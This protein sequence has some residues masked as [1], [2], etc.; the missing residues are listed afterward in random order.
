MKKNYTIVDEEGIRHII[1]EVKQGPHLHYVGILCGRLMPSK[2]Q[3]LHDETVYTGVDED[4]NEPVTCVT[5]LAGGVQSDEEDEELEKLLRESI[6]A[7][8][9]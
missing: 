3:Q 8:K 2:V 6:N 9:N 5:C 1:G 7:A 4:S